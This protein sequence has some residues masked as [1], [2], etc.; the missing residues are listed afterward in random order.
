MT[1]ERHGGMNLRE[2]VSRGTG[3]WAQPFFILTFFILV[4]NL[5]YPILFVFAVLY[6]D[7]EFVNQIRKL[8]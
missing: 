2:E 6:P 3:Q 5:V 1:M 8:E 4:R 7:E